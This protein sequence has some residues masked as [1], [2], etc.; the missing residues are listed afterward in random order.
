MRMFAA[1]EYDVL[2]NYTQAQL[3][4]WNYDDFRTSPRA[5]LP[6]AALASAS[7]VPLVVSSPGVANGYRLP[8]RKEGVFDQRYFDANGIAGDAERAFR[9]AALKRVV[10]PGVRLYHALWDAYEHPAAPP[11]AAPRACPTGYTQVPADEAGRAAAG[12]ARFHC[13]NSAAV[14]GLDSYLRLDAAYGTESAAVVWGA[15]QQFRY[16]ECAGR[17]VGPATWLFS[18]CVPRDDAMPA[19]ADFVAFLAA[20]RAP[21][22]HAA[23]GALSGRLRHFVIW[24]EADS[25]EWFDYSPRVNTSAPLTQAAAGAWLDK[26]AAMLEAAHGAVAG[27]AAGAPGGAPALVYA[28]V[29]RVWAP[30]AGGAVPGRVR[31]SLGVKVLL[32]GL[33]QRLGMR[34]DWAVALHAYGD[35]AA[36]DWGARAPFQGITLADAPRVIAYQAAKLQEARAASGGGGNASAGALAPQELLAA[37]EQ[38]WANP[39]TSARERARNVCLAHAIAEANPRLVWLAHNDFQE[40][41]ATSAAVHGGLVPA[42]AGPNL[43]FEAVTRMPGFLAYQATSPMRWQGLSKPGAQAAAARG[44]GIGRGGPFPATPAEVEHVALAVRASAACAARESDFLAAMAPGAAAAG[45][46]FEPRGPYKLGEHAVVASAPDGSAAVL[47]ATVAD[48]EAPSAAFLSCGVPSDTV[49][50]ADTVGGDATYAA[51]YTRAKANGCAPP[52][53][54]VRPGS[55][56]CCGANGQP[57]A[58]CPV[59]VSG[60]TVTL[61]RTLVPGTRVTW[62]VDATGGGG[63]ATRACTLCLDIAGGGLV[64]QGGATC[65]DDSTAAPTS[66]QG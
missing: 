23:G 57:G 25:G 65:I 50:L 8:A 52:I 1:Q 34:V 36:S 48:R 63:V 33:W 64:C 56:R 38:G 51:K 43:D 18:G 58:A 17:A 39:P 29:D 31:C 54:A 40:V 53:L 55:V 11:S 61:G 66:S 28:S 15:P 46:A 59:T 49:S 37:S 20:R 41:D 12:M 45:L 21:A 2:G 9:Y 19:F 16:A 27:A 3:A 35:P 26:Y 4:L 22:A 30:P 60:A 14:A 5:A 32:D 7:S 10:D 47:A 13:Y 6:A 24:N 42:E 44:P 62:L